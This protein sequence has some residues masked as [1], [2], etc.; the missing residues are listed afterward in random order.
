[1]RKLLL[2]AACAERRSWWVKFEEEAT[3]EPQEEE[4]FQE[5]VLPAPAQM[6]GFQREERTTAILCRP[7]S[8]AWRDPRPA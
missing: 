5:G 4:L 3:P 6:Q 7:S 2:V 8:P 1:M